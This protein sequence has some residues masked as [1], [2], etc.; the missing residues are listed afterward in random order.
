ME[1]LLMLMIFF[2]IIQ[3]VIGFNLGYKFAKYEADK[4]SD[5]GA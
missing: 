5:D 4:E 3:F 2:Q 1:A